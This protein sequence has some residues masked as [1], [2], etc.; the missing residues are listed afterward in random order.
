[1]GL[2]KSQAEKERLSHVKTMLALALADGKLEKNECAAIA[3]VASREN[4]PVEEVEKML[5]GKDNVHFTIPQSDEDKAQ[6]L[7]DL[8]V[9][10]MVDGNITEKELELCR[11]VAENY[12]YRPEVI[13]ALVMSI[14]EEIKKES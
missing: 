3:A 11:A 12:G 14:I 5:E 4:V 6:H 2:F 9:L 8:C 1:M 13:D 10:M 7:K